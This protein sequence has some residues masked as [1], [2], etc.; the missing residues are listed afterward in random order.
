M[1][2]RRYW[3]VD[4][5]D[6]RTVLSKHFFYFMAHFL[7]FRRARIL[8]RSLDVAALS[9]IAVTKTD[10]GLGGAATEAE[11]LFNVI[12]SRGPLSFTRN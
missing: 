5:Q 7:V 8:S 4:S 6:A 10:P 1:L 9:V 2:L 11:T 3:I 12:A